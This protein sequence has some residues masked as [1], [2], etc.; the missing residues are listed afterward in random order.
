MAWNPFNDKDLYATRTKQRLVGQ[1]IVIASKHKRDLYAIAHTVAENPTVGKTLLHSRAFSPFRRAVQSSGAFASGLGKAAQKGASL[2][3]GKIPIPVLNKILDNAWNKFADG[4]R[5]KSHSQNLRVAV[6][7]HDKVKFSL[8]GLGD[9]VASWDRYRWKVD[10]ALEN[11]DKAATE[12]MEMTSSPCDKWVRLWV[13]HL[14]LTNR[15][16]KLR[17]S[18]LAVQAVAEVTSEWLK[19]VEAKHSTHFTGLKLEYDKQV[20]LL[21]QFAGVHETCSDEFCMF[22]NSKWTEKRTVPTSSVA[23]FFVKHGKDVMDVF[24]N[25][26]VADSATEAGKS[27]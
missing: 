11:Y 26:K 8:K 2:A 16:R 7:Q 27:K 19:T 10:K 24:G 21:A 17:E 14:Y 25:E 22:K 4:L 9:Q 6:T 5:E 3:I 20:K 1:G 23:L 12:A 13:K 18:V 15:I